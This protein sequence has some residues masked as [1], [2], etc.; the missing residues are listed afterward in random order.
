LTNSFHGVTFFQ[1]SKPFSH[2]PSYKFGTIPWSHTDSTLKRYFP[3]MHAYMRKY[4]KTSVS[5]GIEAVL[6]A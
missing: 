5:G 2:R 1:L 3:D 4:N 6:S